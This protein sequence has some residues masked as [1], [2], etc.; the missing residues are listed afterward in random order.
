[1]IQR[2][3]RFVRF[4][5]GRL[6]VINILAVL[7]IKL[8]LPYGGA[9]LADITASVT[10]LDAEAI[11]ARTNVARAQANVGPLTH[12]PTL[13]AAAQAKLDDMAAQSYFAHISPTGIQPWDFIIHAGYSYRA[14]GENLAKGF[15]DPA[16]LVQAWL[17]SPAHRQNIV[18]PGYRDIGVAARRVIIDGRSS[19]VVVQMFGTPLPS[20][21]KKSV[22]IQKPKPVPTTAPQ[23]ISTDTH[24]GTSRLT[25]VAISDSS[26]VAQIGRSLSSVLAMYLAGLIAALVAA[27]AI[28]GIK[29]VHLQALV[30]HGA[31]LA[32]VVALPAVAAGRYLIF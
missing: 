9:G 17:N 16:A 26:A 32:L 6:V 5:A 14:A 20:P 19:I 31:L 29:R 22:Q 23:V 24:I 11:I 8:V 28:A 15:S 1:M 13:D 25:A 2:V 18:N 7:V 3:E 10:P 12:N 21:A 27:V 4:V 30:A